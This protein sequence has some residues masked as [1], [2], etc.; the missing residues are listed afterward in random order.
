MGQVDLPNAVKVGDKIMAA[1]YEGDMTLHN[2]M[3]MPAEKSDR[4]KSKK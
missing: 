3:A 1:V 4:Q 2:V